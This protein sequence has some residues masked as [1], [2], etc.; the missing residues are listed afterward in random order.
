MLL[1][2]LLVL[3]EAQEVLD[4]LELREEQEVLVLLDLLEVL[5]LQDKMVVLIFILNL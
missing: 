4:L 2:D 3:Q 5:D 1:L